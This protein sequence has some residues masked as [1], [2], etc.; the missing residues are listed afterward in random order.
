MMTLHE[1]E[2]YRCEGCN[3]QIAVIR[4]SDTSSLDY[5]APRVSTAGTAGYSESGANHEPRLF[6]CD[7]AMVRFCM[8]SA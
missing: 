4:S 7:K 3:A 2:K 1:G 6:C 5:E 8:T